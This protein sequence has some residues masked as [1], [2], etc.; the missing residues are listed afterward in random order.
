[1]GLLTCRP[2]WVILGSCVSTSDSSESESPPSLDIFESDSSSVVSSS[3]F[4][5]FLFVPALP[6]DLTAP[7]PFALVPPALLPV[8]VAEVL[9]AEAL[10]PAFALAV[11]PLL[12]PIGVVG[13]SILCVVF[14]VERTFRLMSS[15][16]GGVPDMPDREREEETPELMRLRIISV[17]AENWGT[18]RGGESLVGAGLLLAAAGDFGGSSEA[19]F[20][21]S[22]ILVS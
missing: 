8:G 2:D 7:L 11:L 1:V 13:I 19:I 6:L 4:A 3:S 15:K 21:G 16:P 14:I 10:P 5:R 12:L 9:D 17:A 20:T 22:L 18:Y